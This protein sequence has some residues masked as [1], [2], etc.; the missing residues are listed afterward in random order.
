[1]PSATF[2]SSGML[3][4]AMMRTS[5]FSGFLSPSGCI[6]P[7]CKKR[8]QLW[9][10]VERQV[11]DLVEEKRAAVGR[12]DHAGRIFDGS[13]KRSFFVAEEMS[14][15]QF[16]WN[17]GAIEGDKDLVLAIRERMDRTRD[18]LL[19]GSG[20]AG[21]EHRHVRRADLV[22]LLD[23]RGHRRRRMDKPGH[24]AVRRVGRR[25]ASRQVG[26]VLFAKR[27]DVHSKLDDAEQRLQASCHHLERR[28]IAD[29]ISKNA[30]GAADAAKRERQQYSLPAQNAFSSPFTSGVVEFGDELVA[31]LRRVAVRDEWI[32][33]VLIVELGD[34]DLAGIALLL[35]DGDKLAE[36]QF[37]RRRRLGKS[38]GQKL[39]N[40]RV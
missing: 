17:G 26:L 30:G 10:N 11:A 28:P 12:S 3:V 35:Q 7:S 4:A 6:S 25:F 9:L 24:H 19:T 37:A 14:L 27:D 22:N 34:D 8:K 5:T 38:D 16:F 21:D 29:S 15:G 33:A 40:D 32:Q 13:G 31:L 20:F 39:R 23:E 36:Q 18:K 2:S 1:M